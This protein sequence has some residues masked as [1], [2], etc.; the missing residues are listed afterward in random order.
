MNSSGKSITPNSFLNSFLLVDKPCGPTSND[1][2]HLLKRKKISSKIGHTGTL[3]PFASGLL[4]VGLGEA[5]KFVSYL[6]EEPKVYEASLKLG[7]ATD[8]LDKMGKMTNVFPVPILDA[9]KINLVFKNFLGPQTQIPPMFSAKK[10]EGKKLYELARAGIEVVREAVPIRIDELILM[11]WDSPL[12]RFRVSC[13]RGTYVRVL[14]A[15]LARKLGSG[16]HLTELRRV[17]AACFD[18]KNAVNVEKEEVSENALVSIEEALSHYP[19]I[20]L[21]KD[22]AL[23]L[24]QGKRIVLDSKGDGIVR[25]YDG[26]LFLGLGKRDGS[27]LKAERLMSS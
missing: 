19:S 9:T 5:L 14:G 26:N 8:T 17:R 10:K 18:V 20:F 11:E 1:V 21:Q 2:L 27:E 12:I 15:D 13:S 6:C 25:S 4:V 22:E 7:E 23:A 24:R 16:G 3:D